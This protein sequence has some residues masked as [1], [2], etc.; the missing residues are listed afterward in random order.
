MRTTQTSEYQEMNASEALKVAEERLNLALSAGNL[1][2]WDMDCVTGKVVFN[3]QKVKMLGY[4]MEDFN[5]V[6]YT[7]FTDLVH[8]DDYEKTMQAMRD[9]LSG[10]KSLYEVEYR[11]KTKDDSYKWFY[12][13]GSILQRDEHGKPLRVKGVVIDITDRKKSELA[14]KKAHNKLQELNTHLEDRV[15]EQTLQLQ[16]LLQQKTDF[17]VQL[18]HDLKTPLGPILNLLPVIKEKEED[19]RLKKMMNIVEKNADLLQEM[20]KKTVKIASITSPDF[21]PRLESVC[22]YDTVQDILLRKKED[23]N[24]KSVQ[25]NNNINPNIIIQTDEEYLNDIFEELILNAIKFSTDYLKI[26]IKSFT[27]HDKIVFSVQDN[28]RGLSSEQINHVFD[29]YYKTDNSRHELQNH[30]LGLTIVHHIVQA[31]GGKIW[32]ESKGPGKGSTFSF[33][34]PIKDE[35]KN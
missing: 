7:A 29:E 1:A 23:F 27:E 33:T 32:A 22:V 30:G 34:L 14:L 8:P 10:K 3:E 9:H 13:R 19:E 26:T 21:K 28:G 4:S 6:D 11:I 5:D 20:V 31:L 18:G 35:H 25:I 12:D 15:H 2:W 17:I 24:Q 16:K